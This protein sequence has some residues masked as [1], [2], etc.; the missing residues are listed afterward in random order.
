MTQPAH[1]RILFVDDEPPVLNLLQTL[2]RHVNPEWESA[3]TDRGPKALALMAHKPFDVVV[4]D[5]RMPEMNGAELL[6]QVRDR[7]P[8]TARIVLS[9]Y[10]DQQMS[11]RSLAAAHQ[12]LSKPFTLTTL[13]GA[14]NRVFGLDQLVADP[15]VQAALGTLHYLPTPPSVHARFNREIASPAATSDTLGGIIG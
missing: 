12:Y 13:Q 9:G 3:F 8:R 4:S 2:F 10:A 7:F 5:M 14:L 6:E 15:D 11:V 1:R